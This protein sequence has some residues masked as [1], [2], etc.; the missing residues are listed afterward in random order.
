MRRHL[1]DDLRQSEESRSLL[2]CNIHGRQSRRPADQSNLI[3]ELFF[4]AGL[5]PA[6]FFLGRFLAALIFSAVAAKFGGYVQHIN[7]I[8]NHSLLVKS[9]IKIAT[10]MLTLAEVVVK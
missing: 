3:K 6:T 8:L 9:L 5:W 10:D 1:S 2:I 4:V 7:T